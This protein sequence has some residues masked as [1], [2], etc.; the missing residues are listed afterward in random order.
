MS[1]NPKRR[2]EQLRFVAHFGRKLGSRWFTEGRSFAEC[3]TMQDAANREA[4]EAL[5][6]E[7]EASRVRGVALARLRSNLSDGLAR[8]A[9]G[10]KLPN[11]KAK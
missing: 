2:D 6:A 10:I 11:R 9:A 7:I 8:F 1:T 5:N 4:F 3:R